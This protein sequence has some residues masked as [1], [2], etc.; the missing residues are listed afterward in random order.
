VIAA[1]V[2]SPVIASA[3]ARTFNVV[4]RLRMVMSL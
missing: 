1:D 3:S 2:T 4:A